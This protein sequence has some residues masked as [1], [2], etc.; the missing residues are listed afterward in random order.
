M[1]VSRDMNAKTGL[2]RGHHSCHANSE[3]CPL[4]QRSY[5][6]GGRLQL[7]EV[8]AEE[9]YPRAC[10]LVSWTQGYYYE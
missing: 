8:E 2:A 4:A 9:Q 1:T 3:E 10:F 7:R 6:R 5:N